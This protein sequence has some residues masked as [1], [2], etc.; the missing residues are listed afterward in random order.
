MFN[1][2]KKIKY[3][4]NKKIYICKTFLSEIDR[5]E[6]SKGKHIDYQAIEPSLNSEDESSSED[7]I[8]SLKFYLIQSEY[9]HD[10]FVIFIFINYLIVLFLI[11][12]IIYN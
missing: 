4:F 2:Y 6:S 10:E 8:N 11:H 7:L 1:F 9:L 3:I 5:V 12:L